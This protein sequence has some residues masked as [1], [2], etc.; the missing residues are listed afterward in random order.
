[1]GQKGRTRETRT[2]RVESEHNRPANYNTRVLKPELRLPVFLSSKSSHSI[3]HLQVNS[4]QP[5]SLRLSQ[6][7]QVPLASPSLRPFILVLNCHFPQPAA[8]FFF[9]RLVIKATLPISC[10]SLLST[11]IHTTHTL[12]PKH[13]RGTFSL[14]Q[15]AVPGPVSA[16][17]RG[18]PPSSLAHS[19]T[20]VH[21]QTGHQHVDAAP[22]T[23][24]TQASTPRR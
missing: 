1:M 17:D 19:I 14:T 16:S 12:A 18:A 11:S 3:D 2:G 9:A 24:S 7:P 13:G 20:L 21:S 5:A 8:V 6:L 23:G 4:A 15:R 10:L 22:K